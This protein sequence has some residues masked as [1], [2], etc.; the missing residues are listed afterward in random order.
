MSAQT[1]LFSFA[2][3]KAPA[4]RRQVSVLPASPLPRPRPTA[5]PLLRRTR[6]YISTMTS[7]R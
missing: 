2:A 4:A 6:L 1:A 7:R 3:V 5:T